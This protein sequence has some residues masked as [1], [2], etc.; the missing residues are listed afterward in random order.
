MTSGE[1]TG[2]TPMS[3]LED[4]VLGGGEL[5]KE[6][7]EV[8]GQFRGAN[9]FG[10]LPDGSQRKAGDWVIR[11]GDAAAW[12]TGKKPKGKGW[13]LDPSSRGDCKW[14]LHVKGRA[15]RRD[16]VVYIRAKKVSLTKD[17]GRS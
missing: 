7:V 5:G 17:P 14:W 16:G 6:T 13:A 15:E 4:L 11:S 3:A 10:D 12:V 9:L 1:R 8:V 2:D